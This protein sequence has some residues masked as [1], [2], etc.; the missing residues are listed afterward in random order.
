[1]PNI[2]AMHRIGEL[3]TFAIWYGEAEIFSDYFRRIADVVDRL[4]IDSERFRRPLAA[5][6]DYASFLNSEGIQCIGSDIAWSRILTW[7]ELIAQSF[8]VPAVASLAPYINRIEIAFDPGAEASAILLSSW[9]LARLDHHPTSV[10]TRIGTTYGT[11]QG[12]PGSPPIQLSLDQSHSVGFGVRSARI[13]AHSGT[14]AARVTIQRRKSDR[15]MVRLEATGM[16]RQERIVHHED[17]SLD[18]LIGA[19]LMHFR[20]DAIYLATLDNAAEYARL[21]LEGGGR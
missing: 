19:E 6:R 13:Q 10:E 17:S 2:I 9:L 7:R 5:L 15:T 21:A 16:P 20:R 1:I 14:G 4:V 8:D 3:P 11:A 12:P 18:E